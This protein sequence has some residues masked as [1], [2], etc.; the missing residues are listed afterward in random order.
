MTRTLAVVLLVGIVAAPPLVDWAFRERARIER[1]ADLERCVQAQPPKVR[2]GVTMPTIPDTIASPSARQELCT[3]AI[4]PRDGTFQLREV[5]EILRPMGALL[6]IAGFMVGAS[7]VGADWQ[8]GFIP[9]LLTWEGRRGRVF[10]AK[11]LAVAGTVVVAIALWQ[12]LLTSVL[13]V[14]ARSRDATDATG[15]AWLQATSGLGLRIAVMAGAAAAFAFA[16]AL[17]ARGTAAAL[18]GGLSYLLVLETVLGSNFKPLRPWLALDNAIVFVKGQYEGGTGGDVP[19]RTVLAAA[20]ILGVYLA[21]VLT[22]SA[23]L[24]RR[25]DVA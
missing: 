7:A 12:F 21:A 20:I 10:A 9:T 8:A 6:I 2:D 5:G 22:V 14:V 4:A 15:G 1:D 13:A 19:G 17:M 16:L 11:L 25:R 18:G 3:Q 23:Q 24:F